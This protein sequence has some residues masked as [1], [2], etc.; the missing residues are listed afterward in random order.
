[1]SQL[2]ESKN[3]HKLKRELGIFATAAIIIGQM[4]GSGIYMAPQGLAELANPKAAVLAMLITGIGT[5]FLAVTF[6][7]MDHENPETGSAII[8]TKK[9]F[10]DLPAFWVG[11]SYW[12]GC[13]VANG[14]IILAG[15]SYAS[16]FFHCLAGN[17]VERWIACLAIIWIYTFINMVGVKQAGGINLILTII[18]IIPIFIFIIIALLH[19]DSDNFNTVSS[20]EVEGLS[21]LPVAIAYS[22]WSYLGFEG[23][24]V[25]AGE[26]KDPKKIGIITIV[27]TGGVVILYLL[28]TIIAAGS[29]DQ[30]SLAASAS[31]LADIMYKA[32]GGK[33]FAGAFI[34]LG[35]SISAIGCVGGWIMSVSRVSYSM[36]EQKLLPDVFAK[37]NERKGTPVGSLIINGILMSVVMTLGYLTNEGGLY[38]FMVLLAVMAFLIFYLFGAAAEIYLVGKKI[39]PFTLFNFLKYSIV[40]LIGLAY[41]IYTVYGSG[42]EYVLYGFL[43]MLFGLPF[44][45]YVKLRN[46]RNE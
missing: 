21:V 43:L 41:S 24:S 9:A 16:Y 40:G 14:A 12:F 32:T 26:V 2:K 10:G 8:Y 23:A 15:L 38:N 37:V 42:A 5:M 3:N 18:K 30:A 25:N 4:V 31:P 36:G 34:A 19:F 28:I 39:K 1:M 11:W 20:P 27:S 29:M 35:G 33:Y 6:A 22:L 45:I 13:W 17:T 44:F 7:K 46:E